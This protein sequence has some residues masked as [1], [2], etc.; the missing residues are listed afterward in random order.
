[1]HPYGP[2][3]IRVSDSV[4]LKPGNAAA[5]GIRSMSRTTRTF[6]VARSE[7]EVVRRCLAS[8]RRAHFYYSMPRS[9]CTRH[10]DRGYPPRGF[11]RRR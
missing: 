10:D 8:S 5:A 7:G 1:M 4:V 3:G 2:S 9:C 11:F 6:C